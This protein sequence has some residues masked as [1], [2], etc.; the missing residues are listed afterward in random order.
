MKVKT[1]DVLLKILDSCTNCNTRTFY[2]YE[3]KIECEIIW[4]I[5]KISTV[6]F[7]QD[8]DRRSSQTII[9][10][11]DYEKPRTETTHF[12]PESY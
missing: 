1:R 3:F 11:Y 6:C 2:I 5:S 8:H 10:V 9:G 7:V 12:Q 4:A